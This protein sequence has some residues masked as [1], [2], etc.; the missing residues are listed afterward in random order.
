MAGGAALYFSGPG[1]YGSSA[2]GH[3]LGICFWCLGSPEPLIGSEQ[4]EST[5][6]EKTRNSREEG[7]R[8]QTRPTSLLV[9]AVSVHSHRLSFFAQGVAAWP[10]REPWRP[11]FSLFK[12]KQLRLQASV[13]LSVSPQDP[14]PAPPP[15]YPR[16]GQPLANIFFFY[17]DKMYGTSTLSF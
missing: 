10:C 8:D 12:E 11:P 16:V 14:L 15:H 3:K 1:F 17:C 9:L 5:Q 7:G 6:L 2:N 4:V 13:F